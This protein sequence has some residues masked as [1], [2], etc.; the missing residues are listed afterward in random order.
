MFLLFSMLAPYEKHFIARTKNKRVE[1]LI[2]FNFLFA[3]AQFQCSEELYSS[4]AWNFDRM[5]FDWN[6]L[7]VFSLTD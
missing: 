2:I 5:N 6:L 4:K 3:T 7:I 1:I